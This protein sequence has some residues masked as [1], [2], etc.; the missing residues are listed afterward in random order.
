MTN[1]FPAN[2]TPAE[3]MHNAVE[4][5]IDDLKV[6][7]ASY[8]HGNDWAKPEIDNVSEAINILDRLR[9]SK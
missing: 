2:H 1:Y 4:Y 9:G 6:L 8:S 7:T 5:L 3:S